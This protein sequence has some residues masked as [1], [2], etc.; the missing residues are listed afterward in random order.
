MA[1]LRDVGLMVLV[2]LTWWLRGI[3]TAGSAKGEA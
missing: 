1:L 3:L 2:V